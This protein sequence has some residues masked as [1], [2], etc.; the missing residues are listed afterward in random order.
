MHLA[1][2]CKTISKKGESN[3]AVTNSHQDYLKHREIHLVA[4]GLYLEL[5]KVGSEGRV[6]GIKFIPCHH[7]A[8]C[9]HF[10][11]DRFYH[12]K[13]ESIQVS[14]IILVNTYI[15]DLKLY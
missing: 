12:L 9:I 11:E 3:T 15:T 7:G 1:E 6:C 13:V 14:A 10:T 8:N 4:E 2:H 5:T